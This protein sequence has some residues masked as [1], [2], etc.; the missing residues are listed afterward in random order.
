VRPSVQTEPREGADRGGASVQVSSTTVGIRLTPA[1]IG[2]SYL[3]SLRR[4]AAGSLGCVRLVR[5]PRTPVVLLIALAAVAT[6]CSSSPNGYSSGG[7]T[8]ST[9]Y[10]TT[11]QA[12]EPAGKNPSSIAKEICSQTA[13]TQIQRVLGVTADVETPTWAGHLY[14]C[15]YQYSNGS[16][17]LSVK[18]LS[19]WPQTYAYFDSL[20]KSRGDTGSL[21]NLGQGAFTTSDG[22]VVVRKDWKVLLVNIAPLPAQ[23]GKPAT[24]KSDVA[25]TVAD[26]ILACWAGD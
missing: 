17:L 26:I 19:S 24:S 18:E 13:Q 9:L 6:A 23:F 22:S 8:P 5:R 3:L 7:S 15:R 11:L 21:G 4:F 12:P 2:R 1:V 14:T 16:F 10:T 20:K 25:Y